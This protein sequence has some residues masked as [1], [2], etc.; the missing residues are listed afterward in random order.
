M[1]SSLCFSRLRREK[2][3]F[4]FGLKNH[5]LLTEAPSLRGAFRSLWRV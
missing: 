5:M 2:Q 3:V 1:D 4:Y